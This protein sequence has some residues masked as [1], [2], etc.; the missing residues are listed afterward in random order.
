VGGGPM[1]FLCRIARRP[2]GILAALFERES[3]GRGQW[4]EANL[5]QAP[6]IHGAASSSWYSYLV[7]HQWPDA[8][9]AS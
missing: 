8:F 5:A 9:V 2:Q 6:T 3:S 4:V 1:V 7:T